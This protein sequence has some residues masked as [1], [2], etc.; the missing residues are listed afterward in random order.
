MKPLT[1]LMKWFAVFLFFQLAI[2]GPV[3][4]VEKVDGGTLKKLV[5]NNKWRIKWGGSFVTYW[6]WKGDGSVCA[7][8]IDAKIDEKCADKGPWRIEKNNLCWE[9]EWLGSTEGYR[10]TCVFVESS[11]NGKFTAKRVKGIG[12]PYF[13]FTV[14]GPLKR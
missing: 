4:G 13:T 10:K 14:V 12:I 11:G 1:K 3:N 8:A 7:R 9:L 5:E 2:Y 6:D